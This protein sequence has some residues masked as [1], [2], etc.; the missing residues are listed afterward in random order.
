MPKEQSVSDQSAA[1][2]EIDRKILSAL[3]VDGRISFRDLGQRVYLSPNATAERVRRLRARGIIRGLHALLDP[4]LLGISVEAYIDV[5]LQRG[6]SAKDFETA[7][8]KLPG[9]TSM[10]IL[11][12]SFD[13][14][15][16]V[17]CKHQAELMHLIET[18][19]TQMG[20]HET[21]SSV[22]CHEVRSGSWNI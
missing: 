7:V 6:T 11:T 21:S 9:I 17:A 12:G 1:I 18:L 8:L 20:V 10:A 4:V 19:R 16:R 3:Y 2:D 14:R 15:L 5:K 13:V 22:I